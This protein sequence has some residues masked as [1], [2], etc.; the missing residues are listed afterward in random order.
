MWLVKKKKVLFLDFSFICVNSATLMFNW[1]IFSF[2]CKWTD[3]S[4]SNHFLTYFNLLHSMWLDYQVCSSTEPEASISSR[5]LVQFKCE[6]P[7]FFKP[8]EQLCSHWT[9]TYWK[10]KI[11]YN[12]SD[13]AYLQSIYGHDTVYI[14]QYPG[15]QNR[16]EKVMTDLTVSPLCFSANKLNNKLKLKIFICKKKY[17]IFWQNIII[18]KCLLI[19]FPLFKNSSSGPDWTP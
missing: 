12:T 4:Q 8:N 17:C 3:D 16:G 9:G 1:A 18:M 15:R 14:P 11:R 19:F 6:I 5:K 10:N 13:S 2:Q 7:L